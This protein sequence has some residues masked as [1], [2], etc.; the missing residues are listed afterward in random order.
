MS[1]NA[2]GSVGRGSTPAVSHAF[3]NAKP[4]AVK[5][6]SVSPAQQSAFVQARPPAA[7]PGDTNGQVV[8]IKL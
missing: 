8:D 1:L 4:E 3:V 7:A 5:N 2:A 6:R